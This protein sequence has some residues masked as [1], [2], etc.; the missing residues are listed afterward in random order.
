[1]SGYVMA[2]DAVL[3]YA[4]LQLTEKQKAEQ[5]RLMRE[6]KEGAVVVSH[7]NTRVLNCHFSTI[8]VERQVKI[9]VHRDHRLIEAMYDSLEELVADGWVLS[10][11]PYL[12]DMVI[13]V[14]H[15]DGWSYPEIDDPGP[16]Y[17]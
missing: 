16:Y 1:M 7:I 15:A 17:G 5:V 13:W 10:G 8:D 12:T 14:D 2:W 3:S 4:R 9:I 6:F 11:S